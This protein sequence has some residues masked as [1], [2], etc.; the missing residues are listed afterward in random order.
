MVSCAEAFLKEKNLLVY[1]DVKGEL[2]LMKLA[3]YEMKA[4]YS[5][6]QKVKAVHDKGKKIDFSSLLPEQY[7]YAVADLEQRFQQKSAGL[8]QQLQQDF[9]YFFQCAI[10]RPEAS[11]SFSAEDVRRLSAIV[12]AYASLKQES[13]HY[14]RKSLM[15]LLEKIKS[16]SN[17]E[18]TSL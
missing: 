7:P 3:V 14:F 16:S 9:R 2:K 18:R 1:P 13:V 5:L 10:D 11:N 12:D 4:F 15:L 8:D 6:L 17:K